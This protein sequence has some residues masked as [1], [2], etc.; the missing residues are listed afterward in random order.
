MS[1]KLKDDVKLSKK[2]NEAYSIM[3]SG[4]NIF[5]TGAAGVGKTQVLK[6]FIKVYKQ[7][8]IMGVTSTT[9]ISALLFGGTTLHSFLGIG[10]GNG[11]VE[12]ICT[13]IFSRSYLNKR[14]RDLEVLVIDEI[15]MLSPTLFDKLEEVARTVRRNL[16]PFGGIQLILSGDFCQ[17]PCINSDNFCF[18]ADSWDKCIDHTIYLTEIMRQKDI[19]FQECLNEV[20][21]GKLSKTTK[22]LLKSRLNIKLTNEFGIL[23]TRL[24]STNRSVDSLNDTE[25]DKL[26]E[27]NV[28]FFEY[29]MDIKYAKKNEIAVDMYKKFCSAPETIQL[30]VG[31]QVMLLWNLDIEGG[32]VNGSRGIIINFVNNLPLV[33]FLNGREVV[34][35][36]HTWEH[37]EN[38]KKILTVFQIPL[39]LAY[40]L[41]IH[42][43]QGCSLDYAEI[44][45]SDCFSAGQ[46]YVALSRVKNLEG[47]SII[48]I[49]FDK[50]IT[51]P[52]AVCFYDSYI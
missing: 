15:S 26:S 22:K 46:S 12:N 27:T 7:T 25:L 30:C 31:A 21:I 14:W 44:D 40:A 11:S 47:L 50:I 5:L 3:A 45:L 20:R 2:Q 18:E 28:E 39:K 17:L 48:G 4:K 42:R 52:K 8:K 16:K 51:H 10:L 38:D 13:K 34:I 36:Y 23:P 29:N 19:E 24:Y 35:D 41:T 1:D 43:S 37:E 6:L 9:G 33:K 49:D 32:L